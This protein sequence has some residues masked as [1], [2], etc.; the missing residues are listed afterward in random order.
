MVRG[1]LVHNG[2][3]GPVIVR[4]FSEA[5]GGDDPFN[6]NLPDLD[7]ATDGGV[8]FSMG[9]EDEEVD[10]SL[11]LSGEFGGDEDD[12]GASNGSGLMGAPTVAIPFDLELLDIIADCR[13]A[14]YE[15]FSVVFALGSEF[16]TTSELEIAPESGR[17]KGKNNRADRSPAR[18]ADFRALLKKRHGKK[19]DESKVA[20]IP[21]QCGDNKAARNLA[22]YLSS[23]EPVSPTLLGIQS[24]KRPMPRVSL[25]D[26]EVTLLLGLAHAT[27]LL[28]TVSTEDEQA[29][30]DEHHSADEASEKDDS[31]GS[32]VLIVRA[33]PEDTV[34]MF[35]D[36]G[37]LA[38]YENLRSITTY[39][40]PETI[41]SRVLLLQDE[42]GLPDA[43]IVTI[44]ADDHE[45]S[46]LESFQMFF[47]DSR[48]CSLRSILPRRAENE[49]EALSYESV[50]ASAV[51]LRL[52]DDELYKA[53]FQE[54]N[55][56]SGKL[57]KRR[58]Q[59]PFSWPIAAM[60]TLMFCSAL[61]FVFRYY[62]QL[63]ALDL[64][65]YELQ[66]Y[67]EQVIDENSQVL[68]SRIDS[69]R[70]ITT[71]YVRSLDVLDSLLVGSDKWSRALES[72]AKV[73][74]EV[75]GIWIEQWQEDDEANY[76]RLKGNSTDRND[77]VAFAANADAIIESLSFS[78]IRGWPVFSFSMKMRMADDLPQAARYF[79]EHTQ[80]KESSRP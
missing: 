42:F 60:Y 22:V 59:L 61:F 1:V 76:L 64:Y 78:E 28:G 46:L 56:L 11:F 30:I 73:S 12:L 8:S 57:L 58:I 55:F 38:R 16:L 52:I 70:M 69:L 33:G 40:P 51:T 71:G 41:C 47:P 49:T 21:M 50:L 32:K 5:R 2:P 31:A 65:R 15:D 77:V 18:T 36:D 20:L 54:V 63:H 24:R 17:G 66:Q 48:V 4:E 37:V 35:L 26:G 62:S 9:G 45:D 25:M 53:V 34:V 3:D 80:D 6:M 23:L 75:G 27:V 7:A 79:R 10:A 14:G 43:D 72:T 44:L 19:S 68:Q 67:P 13:E 29:A 39:D 74:S